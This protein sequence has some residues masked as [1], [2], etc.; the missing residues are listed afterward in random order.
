MNPFE[1][2]GIEH[3]YDIDVRTAENRSPVGGPEFQRGLQ[4]LTIG[5]LDRSGEI[6]ANLRSRP[7]RSLKASASAGMSPP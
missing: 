3:A 2:L 6:C 7:S 1:T 5:Q 4:R